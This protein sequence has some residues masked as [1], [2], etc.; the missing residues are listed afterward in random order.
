MLARAQAALGTNGLKD[1]V[2]AALRAAV[3]QSARTRLAERIASGAG[4]DRSEA[5]F[6]QTRPA[7]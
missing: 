2:D 3:R 5:L 7:R 6:A 4:I 1:T